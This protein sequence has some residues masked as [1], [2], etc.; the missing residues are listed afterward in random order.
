ML[1]NLQELLAKKPK[2]Q[3]TLFKK[4]IMYYLGFA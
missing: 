4:S 1:C 2:M 3:E